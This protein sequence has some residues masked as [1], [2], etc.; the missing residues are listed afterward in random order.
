MGV[1]VDTLSHGRMNYGI[2][3]F[4]LVGVPLCDALLRR[5]DGIVPLFCVHVNMECAM[6]MCMSA[7]LVFFG[8]LPPFGVDTRYNDKSVPIGVTFFLSLSYILYI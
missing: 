3:A 4:W 6:N 1:C 5:C 2:L 8:L 7:I